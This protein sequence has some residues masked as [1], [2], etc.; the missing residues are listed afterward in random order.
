M[1]AIGLGILTYIVVSLITSALIGAYLKRQIK[2]E[3][4]SGIRQWSLL[5]G[6]AIT[7]I[8]W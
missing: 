4:Y 1:K 2:P 8:L 7:L 6:L 3:E 5:I